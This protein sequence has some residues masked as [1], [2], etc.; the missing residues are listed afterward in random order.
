VVFYTKYPASVMALRVASSDGKKMPPY[1]F[2]VG[3]KIGVGVYYE[4]LRYK[5]LPWLM[6]NYPKG[7]YVWTQNGAPAHTANKK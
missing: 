4:V 6:A 5:I 2:K 7:H 1:F 3:E